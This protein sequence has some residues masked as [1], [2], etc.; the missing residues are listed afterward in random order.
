MAAEDIPPLLAKSVSPIF[1]SGTDPLDRAGTCVLLTVFGC[2][3]IASAAHA[4]RAVANQRDVLLMPPTLNHLV[5]LGK[6]VAY[7]TGDEEDPQGLDVGFIPCTPQQVSTLEEAGFLFVP[8]RAIDIERRPHD[9]EYV[10]F[11]W[12]EL[13]GQCDIDHDRQH[14]Y[15]QS[16]PFW[17]GEVPAAVAERVGENPDSHLVLEFNRKKVFSLETKQPVTPPDPTGISGGVA[18]YG[19]QANK[20]AVR[21]AGLVVR[22]YGVPPV[23]VATRMS[24][25]IGFVQQIRNEG[26]LQVGSY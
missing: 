11:G 3:V 22:Q 1:Y 5:P 19:N 13:D 10:L 21:I 23:M 24:E 6:S 2:P 16:F 26:Y 8:E 4:L 17:T 25:F 14:I 7:H 12:P 20:G 9:A 18:A 15:Q